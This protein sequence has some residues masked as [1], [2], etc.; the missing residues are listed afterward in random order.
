MFALSNG[1]TYAKLRQA[2]AGFM[3]SDTSTGISDDAVSE[4]AT[5]TPILEHRAGTSTLC[6]TVS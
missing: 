1:A 2:R 4:L 5:W 3:A 6:A